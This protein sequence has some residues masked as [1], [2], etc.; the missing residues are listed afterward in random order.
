MN[1]LNPKVLLNP[2]RKVFSA[3]KFNSWPLKNGTTFLFG[4]TLFSSVFRSKLLVFKEGK[5]S[6]LKN[7][8]SL[9]SRCKRLVRL[10]GNS[11]YCAKGFSGNTKEQ[12]VISCKFGHRMM[13]M[14]DDD[15]LLWRLEGQWIRR[16]LM[17]LQKPIRIDT[18]DSQALNT[19]LMSEQQRFA[20]QHH[21]WN[22]TM[23]VWKNLEMHVTCVEW[24]NSLYCTVT[25]YYIYYQYIKPYCN[26]S[27]VCNRIMLIF[28]VETIWKQ[29][30]L[31]STQYQQNLV[32][33]QPG[34]TGKFEKIP[35]PNS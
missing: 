1:P 6:P 7:L 30:L 5:F 10:A 24:W 13:R 11:T 31:Q 29:H 2:L 18:V 34:V 14:I 27:F 35:F 17:D 19:Y 25:C 4:Y 8:K 16:H 15:W 22:G 28:D 21:K 26:A 12:A 23:I 33:N 32:W 20:L 3:L 9:S